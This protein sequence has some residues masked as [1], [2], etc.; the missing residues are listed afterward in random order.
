V[1]AFLSQQA[2]YFLFVNGLALILLAAVLWPM[3]RR[4]GKQVPWVWLAWFGLL[5]GTHEWLNLW[6]ME[7]GT[8]VLSPVRLALMGGSL[9]CLMEFGRAGAFAMGGKTPGRWI[10]LLAFALVAL[11]GLAGTVGLEAVPY[12]ALR[13]AAG[14]WAASALWQFQR[15]QRDKGGA[16]RVAALA[17][18]LYGVLA[19]FL[20]PKAPFLPASVLNAD[21]LQRVHGV[22]AE[23]IGAILALAMAV[24]FWRH[25]L[26]ESHGIPDKQS[27]LYIAWGYLHLAFL[28]VALI[29]GWIGVDWK[30]RTTEQK[31]KSH[32]VERA[33]TAASSINWQ[34][35]TALAGN[36]TDLSNAVYPQLKEQI[37]KLRQSVGDI[38]FVYLTR[39]PGAKIIFLVDSES[40]D[41]KEYSPPG[42]AYPEATP[43]FLD[44]FDNGIA[45]TEGPT[46]D[47]WGTWV[48][49]LAP[50]TAED[51]HVVAVLGMDV[52][53]SR[54]ATVIGRERFV[55]ILITL[56]FSA[57]IILS[58]VIQ[59]RSRQAGFALA[60]VAS[61]QALLL[62][63]IET[64]VWYLKDAETYGAVNNAHAAFLGKPKEAFELKP[65]REIYPEA[66][67]MD[68]IAINRAIFAEKR[69]IRTEEW[70]RD[71]NGVK[72]LLSIIKTPKLDPRGNVEFV[73]CSAEDITAVKQAE[74]EQANRVDRARRQQV[75]LA[76]IASD[77]AIIN[78][79]LDA[80]IKKITELSSQTLDVERVSVWM[81]DSGGGA[82]RR[83]DLY[84]KG[85]ETNE[86]CVVLNAGDY[87]AYFAALSSGRAIDAQD[88]RVDERTRE[89]LDRYLIPL[90]ITS[91]LD[92]P[93]RV[94]GRVV[95]VAC[96]EHVGNTPRAP[97]EPDEVAFASDVADQVANAILSDHRR[98]AEMALRESEERL[99]KIMAAL[100]AGV[101]IVDAR[102]K[103]ILDANPAALTMIGLPDSEVIGVTS[104][105]FLGSMGRRPYP[106]SGAG[107]T[108]ESLEHVLF[109][110]GG[111]QTPILKSSIPVNLNGRECS[112]VSFVDI[113]KLTKA[114]AE[115]RKLW[116][117]LEQS[118][119]TVVITD[120]E[121]RIEYAN[122]SFV[123][124]TGYSREETIGSNPRVLKSG[125]H[126]PEFYKAMWA[127]LA[128]GDVWRGELCNRK[129]NGELYWE[130][131]A[132]APVFSAQGAITHYVA[133]KE[134]ISERRQ[135][136]EKLKEAKEAAEAA[137]RAKSAFLANMSHE[138]R[139]PMN[140]I[141]GFSQLLQRDPV[142]TPEQRGLLKSINRSGEHLMALI[143]DILE[144][145]KIEAGRT[146]VNPS[147]FDLHAMIE[148]MGMMFRTRAESKGLRF[149][150][151]RHESV[152]RY[153]TT[154][155]NKVRQILINLLGNAV[156]FTEQGGITLRVGTRRADPAD[157]RLWAEV[158]DTGPGIAAEE[159]G[160]LFK[161][162][163]QT[164]SGIRVQGGT[165]LGL[166][167]SREFARLLGGD[168]NVD[169]RLGKGSIFRFD[170]GIEVGMAES[171][172]KKNDSRHMW[173]L[174]PGEP[175]RRVLVVDDQE[176]NRAV[177]LLMLEGV[178]FETREATNGEEAIR[179]HEA[180]RPHLIL[181]D[182]RMPVMDG[183][184]A[185]RRIRSTPD[186]QDVKIIAVTANAFDED[187]KEI[188]A[189]GANDFLAKPF[190]E[191]DLFGMI[192][193]HLGVELE[194][195]EDSLPV[196]PATGVL[197]AALTPANLAGLPAELIARMRS[198]ATDLDFDELTGM[199][200]TIAHVSPD[201]AEGL[202]KLAE[203]FQF[204]QLLGLLEP[205]ID[206]RGQAGLD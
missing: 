167:I 71:S 61:E 6:G 63:M 130:S 96:F 100:P 42:Q 76:R 8:A 204:D 98:Q 205:T 5:S 107:Q 62:G 9:L 188:L 118:P 49:S 82:L 18:S 28:G 93:I 72:R 127:T 164:S 94:D 88:A 206:G 194:T 177:L 179:E 40:P 176:E 20:A 168:V 172:E 109:A 87:P 147:T 26:T 192:G 43:E 39:K 139:T 32:L 75:Q 191:D 95:G 25:T 162:F 201:I 120:P 140:A 83:Q 123:T 173:T 41:S 90:G 37:K 122:P 67:L 23:L 103:E 154:D 22:P 110:S 119:A 137:N 171:I 54:W 65:L 183:Q 131:A 59:Q 198:A 133:V 145:S 157:L 106:V 80:A 47:R 73:V 21:S 116:Q 161:S 51:G 128:K 165:G 141:L 4:P 178:G 50:V 44:I 34:R 132:I 129:K 97:W 66:E 197:D 68:K 85:H 190:R 3:G 1:S 163:Q 152:P 135:I 52:D 150:L 199:I 102:T 14:L 121:G 125:V 189:L 136:E 117:A 70:R 114:E 159:T 79:Q 151:E 78:G 126:P 111:V 184:E 16:L 138:I 45:Y 53:A 186:G 160:N 196:T 64:Q 27:R 89:F 200:D 185:I 156:K 153:V 105:M 202:R 143:N 57:L 180:W 77:P 148:D 7:L 112:V 92:A 134:D 69:Q 91:M 24:A 175:V 182:M 187:R 166:A 170:I 36:E 158:E 48:S 56:L 13:P 101:C 99:K 30:G 144:M 169:S 203:G 29:A 31:E 181:M 38:R 155:D 108:T 10:Y 115:L 60:R 142:I 55:S 124:I 174:R 33:K 58:D 193:T 35:V 2:D 17:L 113:T 12:Y 74:Q 195:G 81:L 15:Q 149:A 46:T 86:E 84:R 146:T 11:G 19:V 104:D